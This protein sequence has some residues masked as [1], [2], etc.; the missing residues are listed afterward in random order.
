V[1]GCS[2]KLQT[3]VSAL[4]AV[5]GTVVTLSRG[6]CVTTYPSTHRGGRVG[7]GELPHLLR[8]ADSQ[9][10]SSCPCCNFAGFRELLE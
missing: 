7:D 9:K 6:R 10:F 2:Q 4:V 8:E 1:N 5:S 3:N